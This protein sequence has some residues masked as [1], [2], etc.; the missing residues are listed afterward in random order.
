MS[1]SFTDIS[2][3]AGDV[4]DGVYKFPDLFSTDARGRTR[5]WTVQ[6]RLI[7]ATT[8]TYV[9]NWELDIDTIVA[10]QPDNLDGQNDLPDNV[11]AQIWSEQC[12]I[13]GKVS[14]HP[15]NIIKEGKLRGRA[16]QRNAL[17]QA[18]IA[19]RQSWD[20]KK[21]NGYT[22]DRNVE[23]TK[24]DRYYAMAAYVYDKY[25]HRVTYPVF[26]QPKLDGV[27]CVSRLTPSGEVEMYSR[28]HK[29]FVGFPEIVKAI[30]GV[31]RK[32]G[33]N[34]D[35]E[36]YLHGKNL[37]HIVGVVRNERQKAFQLEY[38]VFDCYVPTAEGIAEPFSGRKERL[39]AVFADLQSPLV[40]RV[41]TTEVHDADQLDGLY[42]SYIA[43]GYEGQMVR[44][45]DGKYVSNQDREMRTDQ[46]LKRKKRFTEE[47]TIV[48]YTSGEKGRAVGAIIFILEVDEGGKQFKAQPKN[49]TFA[50]MREMY[51]E[52]NANPDNYIGQL[53]TLEFE[54]LSIDNVPLRP[55]FVAIRDYE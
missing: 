51:T 16:N 38:H 24:D 18:L 22:E 46:L 33:V 55:K 26:S 23:R 15:P 2:T 8:Q 50:A 31:L 36:L 19:A 4:Y 20:K 44:T 35:G 29:I 3:F 17:T 32:H 12:I 14:R 40:V 11:W 39:D 34:L 27:R 7:Q 13:D 52:V 47:F 37:Q 30:D 45:T 48:G 21:D 1:R 6:V 42:N 53:A 9:H 49:M 28:D 25:S 10:I 41:S 54:D 43:D 5:L